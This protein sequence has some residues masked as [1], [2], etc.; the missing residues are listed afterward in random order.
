VEEPIKIVNL[1]PQDSINLEADQFTVKNKKRESNMFSKKFNS[2]YSTHYNENITASLQLPLTK[3]ELSNLNKKPGKFILEISSFI[4]EH[5]ARRMDLFFYLLIAVYR[6]KFIISQ[7]PTILQHGVGQRSSRK[8]TMTNACHSSFFPNVLQNGV[9]FLQGTHLEASFNSTVELPRFIN[10]L[11]AKLEGKIKTPSTCRAKALTILQ[12][13]SY[14]KITPMKGLQ[15]FAEEM[16][17]T[18]S[19]IKRAQLFKE[20]GV[21]SESEFNNLVSLI[22]KGTFADIKP[23]KDEIDVSNAYFNLHL[24]LMPNEIALINKKPKLKEKNYL[25]KVK[26]IQKEIYESLTFKR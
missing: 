20:K 9:N 22:E 17:T 4:Q 18:L 11:D 1:K 10:L 12:E 7:G 23:S 26:L 21:L 3:R 25:K 2:R 8:T 19:S 14:G 6:K 16:Q 5:A 13:T 24:R 15:L